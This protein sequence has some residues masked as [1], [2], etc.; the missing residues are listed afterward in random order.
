MK[1]NLTRAER[2]FNKRANNRDAEMW[3]GGGQGGGSGKPKHQGSTIIVQN[4]V[5]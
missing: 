2:G 5:H 1:S 4:S 3:S